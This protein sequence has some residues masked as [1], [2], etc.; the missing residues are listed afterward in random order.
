M[1]LVCSVPMCLYKTQAGA[2]KRADV[3]AGKG[4]GAEEHRWPADAGKG[5]GKAAPSLDFRFPGSGNIRCKF[6]LLQVSRLEVIYPSSSSKGIQVLWPGPCW[7]ILCAHCTAESPHH[8]SSFLLA[9]CFLL[10]PGNV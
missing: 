10:P 1:G 4:G 9:M 2:L 8:A 7:L 6:G 3:M 5:G